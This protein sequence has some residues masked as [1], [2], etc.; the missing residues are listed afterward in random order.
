MR[1]IIALKQLLRTPI[2]T[3]LTFL[4]LS[5]ASFALFS[6]VMDYTVTMREIRNAESF[7]SGVAALD[8][9]VPM[10]ALSAEV[11][12]GTY[13]GYSYEAEDKPWPSQEQLEEFSSLPGVTLT[14]Q[15]YMTAGLI[16]DYKRLID[17]DTDYNM[18]EFILEGTYRGYEDAYGTQ[19]DIHL[20]F[21]DVKV[22]AGDFEYDP[23]GTLDIQADALEDYVYWK[24]PYPRSYWEKLE[25]GSRC[26]V[27]GSYSALSRI[28]L[29]LGCSGILDNE[30]YFKVIDG[31]PEDYLEMPEFAVQ[32]KMVEVYN[33]NLEVYDIVYTSDMR[34]IPRF[35]E[36][37]MV[38]AEGR[39]LTA[40]DGNGCVVSESFLK[41]HHRSIGDKIKVRLGDRLLGQNAISGTQIGF[42]NEM[43]VFTDAVELEIIGAYKFAD[44][45]DMRIS[46]SAWCY[47]INAV[48][49]PDSLLPVEVPADYETRIG[50]FSVLIE[51]AHDI[52]AFLEASEP[53][54]TKMGINMRF[55]D[56]GWMKIKD[57]F[58]TGARTALLTMA[59]YVV[60]AALALLLAVYLYV[61]RNR[62]AYAIMRTLGVSV[63]KAQDT[64]AL[65]FVALSVFAIPI[66]GMAGLFYAKDVAVKALE[67]MTDS[68]P[69]GYALDAGLPAGV[70]LLCL[71]WEL[72]FTS[73]ITMVSLWK[74]KK[75]PPLELL[76]GNGLRTGTG[77]K[78]G[79]PEPLEPGSVPVGI[80]V[81][82]LAL[83]EFAADGGGIRSRRKYRAPRQVSAYILR[84]MRRSTGKTAVSFLLA[85]VLAAGIGLFVM[86]Q[87][88]YQ[89]AF[90]E[91]DVMG[92][93]MGY[94]S[95]S[96]DQ[97]ESSKLVK[98][99]YYRGSFLVRIDGGQDT[100]TMV[101][102]NNIERYLSERTDSSYKVAY[103]KGYDASSLEGGALCLIGKAAAEAYGLGLGGQVPLL[104][105]T[106]H[107]AMHKN[108]GHD[109]QLLQTRLA[110]A[111]KMYTVAGIVDTEDAELSSSI[112]AVANREAVSLYSMPI[113]MEYSDFLLLDNER[114]DVLSRLLE[115]VKAK[116][117][118]YG[119]TASFYL[120]TEALKNIGRICGLLEGLF[121]IAVAAAVLIGMIVPG[122]VVMQSAKEAAFL[123]V[124][125]VTK[126]RSRCMLVFE[127]IAFC[128]AGMLFVAG[129]LVLYHQGR[130]LRG[131]E[132]LAFCGGV[133]LLGSVCGAFAASVLV[134]RHRVLEL[135][136][137]KE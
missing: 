51:D 98:D 88:T 3:I 99:L 116:D 18:D 129:G 39:M 131:M 135:L 30:A 47:P 104:A 9:T 137:S 76:Q 134:T 102:T 67:A 26:L 133:Y 78:K 71:F 113:Q 64:V 83:G 37:N 6:R 49:V 1:K 13:I 90:H 33:Q 24:N 132:T 22:L 89:D 55:S 79:V 87:L 124:L 53:L 58:E 20:K 61:G 126:K 40:A 36:R 14:D 125:G 105:D 94:S 12:D 91:V 81:A 5:A 109:P 38:M 115:D 84:H 52:E 127:Q 112:F 117:Y 93:A 85:V 73:F 23:E 111:T 92:K 136:H 16:E 106:M 121:P 108:F 21:D 103:A 11:G 19:D 60:G 35:N 54:V 48:F 4:L 8:N 32:K 62:Q 80:T 34:A 101:F 118:Y 97:I 96:I 42:E 82:K 45:Y 59:L 107:E 57:S 29:E 74:M 95:E 119:Q 56:G 2:K 120:D 75:A 17:K 50:E 69:Y 10:V 100:N 86:A 43:P 31:L 15:R 46:E 25:A 27:A 122:L 41:A 63:Q 65:P 110:Y 128:V 114:A 70:I 28:G 130:F 68:A 77:M 44:T 66:G 72:A 123:R 7:Y